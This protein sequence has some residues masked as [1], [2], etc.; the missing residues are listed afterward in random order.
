M[1]VYLL[2][3]DLRIG[4]NPILHELSKRG[5]S[6]ATHLLPIYVFSAQQVEVSGFL[7]PGQTRSPYPE[8]RSPVGHFW[9]C[10]PH[11]ARFLAESVFALRTALERS[12]SGLVVRVGL[13]GDVT[14]SVLEGLK[15]RGS[16]LAGV[17]MTADEASEEKD[18]ERDVRA[19]ATAAGTEL[20]LFADEKYLVDE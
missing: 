1:L 4:D 3:R 20:R 8:A 11:R 18:E 10:G 17:W 7:A 13:L 2:R 5:N 19:A 12:G 6:A 9:R 16:D 14:K 15:D